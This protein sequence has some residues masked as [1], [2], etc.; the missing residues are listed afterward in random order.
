MRTLAIALSALPCLALAVPDA[1]AGSPGY[2]YDEGGD[3][4]AEAAIA[5]DAEFFA[6]GK[7]EPATEDSAGTRFEVDRSEVGTRLA[8]GSAVSAELR[9]ET[10]RTDDDGALTVRAKRAWVAWRETKRSSRPRLGVRAGLV[11]DPWIEAIEGDYDLRGLAPTAAELAG[12]IDP[13]DL[14]LAAVATWKML[15]AQV[16]VTNGEGRTRAETNRDKNT[17]AIVSLRMPPI[18]SDLVVSAH[19]YGRGGSVGEDATRS[20]RLGMAMAIDGPRF[21]GGGETVTAWGVDDRGD[22]SSMSVGIWAYATLVGRTGIAGRFDTLRTIDADDVYGDARRLTLAVWRDLVPRGWSRVRDFGVRGYLAAQFDGVGAM[23][24]AFEDA[25][26][27][28]G[29]TRL[30]V[31]L[32][33]SARE[34]VE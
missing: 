29:A 22:V 25:P 15:R 33:A 14:G 30:M 21:G 24:P 23:A 4:V 2:P 8:Y 18:A 17:S 34:T 26:I 27:P 9:L 32:Q 19:L 7:F 31:I 12:V 3:E 16:A 20:H 10:A 13:S 11:P 28:A 1:A 5:L 6:G